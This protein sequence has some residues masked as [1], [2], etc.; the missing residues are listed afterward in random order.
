VLRWYE[1]QGAAFI[2]LHDERKLRKLARG[3]SGPFPVHL[4]GMTLGGPRMTPRYRSK[5]SR[6]LLKAAFGCYWLEHGEA[7]LAPEWD[8]V[9]EAVL[10]EPRDGYIAVARD[11]DQEHV[12]IEMRT[13]LA[14]HPE[15]Q[16]GITV[17]AKL[18]GIGIATDSI[19]AM[20]PLPLP[21]EHFVVATFTS[22]ETARRT[23]AA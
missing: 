5:L 21:D 12:E 1:E 11:G 14:E 18:Y 3:R 23:R 2:H 22:Q 9:R 13:N 17:V 4:P 10:G 19:N 8:S 6:A 20:P 7:L 15:G 16:I